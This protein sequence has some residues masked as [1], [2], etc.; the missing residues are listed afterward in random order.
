MFIFGMAF[1]DVA[2]NCSCTTITVKDTIKCV[3]VLFTRCN[4][5]K[6][7]LFP[8]S[9]KEIHRYYLLYWRTDGEKRVGGE[10]ALFYEVGKFLH[11]SSDFNPFLF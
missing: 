7:N 6:A 3:Y 8:S 1:V 4:N 10:E 2:N 9:E 11:S 5:F